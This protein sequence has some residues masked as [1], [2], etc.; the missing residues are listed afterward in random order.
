MKGFEP[1]SN[2]KIRDIL[3]FPGDFKGKEEVACRQLVGE[4]SK[5]EREY[6]ARRSYTYWYAV[7]TDGPLPEK[8]VIRVA[9]REALPI[10]RGKKHDY[11]KTLASMRAIISFRKVSR[12]TATHLKETLYSISHVN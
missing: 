9:R 2:Q 3:T 1:L 6:F 8:T 11:E 12:T 5:E 7:M 4:L 10:F